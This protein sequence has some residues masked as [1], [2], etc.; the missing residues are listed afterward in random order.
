VTELNPDGE[1]IP[2]G[3]QTIDESDIEAVVAV[4]RGDWLTQGPAIAAFENAIAERVEAEYA[5]AFANGTAALHGACAAAGIGAGNLAATSPLTFAASANCARYVGADVTFV[6]V[7]DTLCMDTQIVPENVD[8]L[9]PVHFAGYPMDLT[10][11]AH[12]PTMVLEDAAHALGAWGPS[13]PI[14]NCANSDLCSF[15]FHPV[16]PITTGEGGVVT[17]NNRDLAEAMRRFRT[18]G[19]TPTH[20]EGRWSYDIPQLGYNYRLTDLHA[21]L[22]LSQ[23]R[24][25]DEFV[26]RRQEIAGRYDEALANLPVTIPP[27]PPKGSGHGYHIYPIRVANRREVFDQLHDRNI[28]VQVHYKPVPHLGIYSDNSDPIP[29]ATRAYEGLIS[30]PIFPTLDPRAQ[31]RVIEALHQILGEGDAA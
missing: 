27:R 19:I 25:L 31:D 22:G 20:E 10:S 23:L 15:S 4:L 17:T 11:I 9:I 21:A 30:L 6:D 28:A 13:G 29:N 16:K 2:Y 24:R 14:G 18:H 3:R 1:R 26:A 7:D 12:R 8:L 5:V